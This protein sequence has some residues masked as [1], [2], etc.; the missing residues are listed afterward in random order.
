MSFAE[1]E[2]YDAY[3]DDDFNQRSNKM[4]QITPILIQMGTYPKVF[5]TAKSYYGCSVPVAKTLKIGQTYHVEITETPVIKK[6]G[7]GTF[8]AKT[9]VSANPVMPAIGTS[10]NPIGATTA[11][12]TPSSVETNKVIR[13]NMDAKN[14]AIAL[15]CALNNAC[16]M[17]DAYAKVG[18]MTEA[19]KGLNEGEIKAWLRAIKDA[20]F[21]DNLKRLGIAD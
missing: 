20:E 3:D 15:A 19:F 8:M 21:K 7:S 13:E 11:H 16:L 2:G 6:D 14:H 4:E 9:I 18:I 1:D 10:S 17:V 5:L 12:P